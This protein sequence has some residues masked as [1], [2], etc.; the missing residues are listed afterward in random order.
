MT[1]QFPPKISAYCA[2]RCW[3]LASCVNGSSRGTVDKIG[4]VK[5]HAGTRG[6]ANA[7][8]STS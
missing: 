5:F 2:G 8:L 7:F 4:I 1:K 3:L 6:V